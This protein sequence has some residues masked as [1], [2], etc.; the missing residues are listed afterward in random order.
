MIATERIIGFMI[1]LGTFGK[2]HYLFVCTLGCLNFLEKL[3][4]LL[5]LFSVLWFLV[6]CSNT[7]PRDLILCLQSSVSASAGVFFRSRLSIC[8]LQTL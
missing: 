6:S 5:H 3:A 1:H 2:S 4:L 8:I 7:C